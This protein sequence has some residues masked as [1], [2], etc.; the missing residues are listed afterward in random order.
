[1][2]KMKLSPAEAGLIEVVRRGAAGAILIQQVPPHGL[3][4]TMTAANDGPGVGGVGATFEDAWAGM[5]RLPSQNAEGANDQAC[6]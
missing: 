6:D 5:K 1:M 3:I 4:V 2:I